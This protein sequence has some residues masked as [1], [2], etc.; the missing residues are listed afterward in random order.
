VPDNAITNTATPPD[1][2]VWWQPTAAAPV[3]YEVDLGS[4]TVER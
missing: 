1:P 3:T 4:P 2:N